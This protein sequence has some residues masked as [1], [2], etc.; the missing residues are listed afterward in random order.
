MA[1]AASWM[2][3]SVETLRGLRGAVFGDPEARLRAGI[4]MAVQ[5]VPLGLSAA[6]FL[7]RVPGD[8]WAPALVLPAI[9]YGGLVVAGLERLATSRLTAVAALTAF[10]PATYAASTG[11]ADRVALLLWLS[12]GGYFMLDSLFV[13]ARLRRSRKMLWAVRVLAPAVAAGVLA[14]SFRGSLSGV[15]AAAF[16]ILG[17]RAWIP[18]AG[19][20]P[21]RPERLGR[22]ELAFGT[23]SALLIL[24]ALA[25]A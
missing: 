6:W 7:S 10:A 13:M 25:R 2:F 18:T 9:L 21:V 12:L 20:R 17:L 22:V 4:L 14:S 24:A 8:G 15:L 23:L 19:D 16:G 1:G 11:R 5:A 3:L